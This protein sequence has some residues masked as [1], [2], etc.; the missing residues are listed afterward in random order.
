MK[1]RSILQVKLYY[2]I[3]LLFQ[4]WGKT[5]II[6]GCSSIGG[7]CWWPSVRQARLS[8]LRVAGDSPVQHAVL[9]PVSRHVG[10]R[11]DALHHV[12]RKVNIF[13]NEIF[14]WEDFLFY[15]HCRYP[16]HGAE[17]SGLFAKIRR[18]QF[19]LPDNLS[20]RAKCLIKCLLRKDPSE[21]ITTEDVL[22]HPWLLG[23]H[24]ERGV[25]RRSPGL[26]NTDHAVPVW[27]QDTSTSNQHLPST[28]HTALSDMT[29]QTS[30][31]QNSR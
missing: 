22:V 21:R 13:E 27:S 4:D 10:P 8:R 16:F 15:I 30:E 17:H 19:T 7:L 23:S 11:G 20:S 6:G 9:R 28:G 14:C 5:R 24:R 1:Y 31:Q 18:G 25:H 26:D 3:F 2:L 12:S 29:R